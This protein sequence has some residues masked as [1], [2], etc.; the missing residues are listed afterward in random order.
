MEPL[1]CPLH[2]GAAAHRDEPFLIIGKSDNTGRERLKGEKV[3]MCD[4][5][6]FYRRL[7][8]PAPHQAIGKAVVAVAPHG[9]GPDQGQMASRYS[10]RNQSAVIEIVHFCTD[11]NWPR[12]LAS[13]MGNSNV[14]DHRR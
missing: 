9:S 14:K 4:R 2:S 6:R 7:A 5:Y 12:T 3:D 11:G 1:P 10:H 8:W 13:P